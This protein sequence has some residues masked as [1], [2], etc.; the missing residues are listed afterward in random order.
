MRYDRDF[1]EI[2]QGVQKNI[3]LRLRKLSREEART[4]DSGA[5]RRQA[6]AFARRKKWAYLVLSRIIPASE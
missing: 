1:F 2:L 3:G 4:R 5:R 6:V